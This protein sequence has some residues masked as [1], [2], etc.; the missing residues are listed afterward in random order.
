MTFRSFRVRRRAGR[1][2]T[3]LAAAAAGLAVAGPRALAGLPDGGVSV[4]RP[5]DPGCAADFERL[6]A[7][8]ERDYAGYQTAAQLRPAALAA[9]TVTQR[10]AAA[11]APTDSPACEAALTRWLAFFRDGHLHLVPAAPP[12]RGLTGT[13]PIG[14]IE[15]DPA[16]PSLEVLDSATLLLRIPSFELTYKLAIDSLLAASDARLA[17]VPVLIIDV[18]GNGGGGDAAFAGIIPLLYTGPIRVVGADAWASSANTAYF[19]D[20]LAIPELPE[21]VRALVRHLVA[22]MERHP[23][24]FVPIERD[25][26]LRVTA[27]RAAPR[28]V[29]VLYNRGSGSTTEEFLLQARQSRKAV[30]FS[31][32]RS[33]GAL[34]YANVRQVPLPSGRWQLQF[35]TSRS[36]RLPTH[37]VDPFGLAP[38]VRIPSGFRDEVAYVRGYLIK[39]GGR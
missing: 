2:A 13:A 7:V 20:I 3:W 26:V 18:R 15:L 27:Q 33:A 34:D 4:I 24:R 25:T 23:N 21:S 39:R 17:R 5:A 38:T 36:R 16:R 8:A 32:E 6:V 19:R 30:L 35:G 12:E 14:P 37:P 9:V 11:D 29:A 22:E 10:R 1:R 31:Q 28:T